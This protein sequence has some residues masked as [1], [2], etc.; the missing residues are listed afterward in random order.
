MKLSL[1]H[2][3]FLEPVLCD[4]KDFNQC[5]LKE[6]TNK[7]HYSV[8]MESLTNQPFLKMSWQN[9]P[10]EHHEHKTVMSISHTSGCPAG[11]GLTLGTSSSAGICWYHKDRCFCLIPLLTT[12]YLR[13]NGKKHIWFLPNIFT[14]F[15]LIWHDSLFQSI[16]SYLLHNRKT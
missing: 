13:V 12:V 3:L 4:E 10:L 14:Q 15:N 9:P 6:L 5:W 11:Q 16:S 7:G 1:S 2:V 8:A